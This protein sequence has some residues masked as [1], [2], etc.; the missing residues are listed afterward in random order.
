MFL[1]NSSGRQRAVALARTHQKI[2]YGYNC[3]LTE[4][5]KQVIPTEQKLNGE[6][7]RTYP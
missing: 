3:H 4:F 7:F 1:T 5:G 6:I 2:A